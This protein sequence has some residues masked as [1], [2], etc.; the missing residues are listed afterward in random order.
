M[1]ARQQDLRRS[2]S[3]L[4]LLTSR[5]RA[6]DQTVAAVP[7]LEAVKCLA[8]RF[9]P[10]PSSPK[11][12]EESIVAV[13]CQ[14]GTRTQE[15]VTLKAEKTEAKSARCRGAI[16]QARSSVSRAFVRTR[17]GEAK[18]GVE[19]YYS[20]IP[21]GRQ[22]ELPII[23]DGAE[24]RARHLTHRLLRGSCRIG[25]RLVVRIDRARQHTCGVR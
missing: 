15:G 10:N 7:K 22:G 24:V 21:R 8:S 9:G 2:A 19:H 4:L 18:K 1:S 3:I 14:E 13:A 5:A 25:L 16:Q 23:V 12:E 11:A 6:A 17:Q 20:P